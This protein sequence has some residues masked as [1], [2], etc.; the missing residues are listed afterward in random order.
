MAADHTATP[1]SEPTS[2]APDTDV[3]IAHLTVVPVNFDPDEPN[4][5]RD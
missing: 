1:R 3:G 4:G 5:R 2:S